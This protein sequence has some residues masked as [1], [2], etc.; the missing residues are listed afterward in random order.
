[1]ELEDEVGSIAVGKRANVV[2]TKPLSS[3]NELPYRFGDALVDRVLI[4]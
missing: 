2:L 1:M 3:Y 4:G